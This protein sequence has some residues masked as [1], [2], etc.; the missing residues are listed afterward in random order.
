MEFALVPVNERSK[1]NLE[2]KTDREDNAQILSCQPIILTENI[3]D[4]QIP[5]HHPC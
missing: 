4:V 3:Q 2:C 5:G 1:E